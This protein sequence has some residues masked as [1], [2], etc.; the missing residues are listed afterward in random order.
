MTFEAKTALPSGRANAGL[1][2]FKTELWSV[3]GS[4][5]NGVYSAPMGGAWTARTTTFPAPRTSGGLV[6]FT[7]P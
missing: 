2:W 7:P 4:D 5:N 6:A 3:G 1:A